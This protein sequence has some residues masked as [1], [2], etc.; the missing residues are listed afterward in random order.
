VPHPNVVLFDVRVG[1]HRRVK[2]GISNLGA[3]EVWTMAYRVS[4]ADGIGIVGIILAV[5]CLVLD[6]AG[7]LKGGWLV[8]LLVLAGAMTLFLAI[9]NSWVLDAPQKWKLWR[10]LLMSSLVALTYSGLA[11]W[12]TVGEARS[13]PI[14]PIAKAP[15]EKPPTLL[16]LFRKDF[17]NTLKASDEDVD[18]YTIST[19]EG[20]AIKVKRQTYEDYEARTKFVGFYISRPDPPSKDFSGKDTFAACMELLKHNAVQETFDHFGKQVAVMSGYGD[21]M[22]TSKELTFSGRVVIYHEEFLSIPQ[23]ADILKEYK[24]KGLAVTFRGSDYLG[25]EAIAWHQQHDKQSANRWTFAET[26]GQTERL[27]KI[28]LPLTD[29]FFITSAQ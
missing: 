11:I 15:D 14:P 24:E 25:T 21:Q 22:T 7:K 28:Q 5:V 20:S 18:A 29:P 12:I 23:K 4:F 8:G 3:V 10:G 2:L 26:R 6:K 17:T 1:F 19:P 16:D 9:G 27:P 13:N